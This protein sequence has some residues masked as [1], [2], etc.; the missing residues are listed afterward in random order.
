MNKEE[1]KKE[2]VLRNNQLEKELEKLRLKYPVIREDIDNL[3]L[4]IN[5]T[6]K[7]CKEWYKNGN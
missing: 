3:D 4:L 5:E 7:L 1:L 6:L 2:V